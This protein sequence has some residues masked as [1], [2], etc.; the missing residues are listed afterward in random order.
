MLMCKIF[1]HK[2][3]FYKC[4]RC[5]HKKDGRK[6]VEY[7]MRIWG[8]L[9]NNNDRQEYFDM[10]LINNY[11]YNIYYPEQVKIL[12]E[13]RDANGWMHKLSFRWRGL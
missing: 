1:G 4:V 9:M 6:I 13:L 11:L 7:P 12:K 3:R 10:F 8:I 5:G 2:Y